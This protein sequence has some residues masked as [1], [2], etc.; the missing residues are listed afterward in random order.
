M[1]AH[2]RHH[3][4]RK[5]PRTWESR[6][7]G[8]VVS[9]FVFV[10]KQR[11]EIATSSRPAENG[12]QRSL[13]GSADAGSR[14]GS[15]LARPSRRR[16]MPVPSHSSLCFQRRWMAICEEKHPGCGREFTLFADTTRP[17]AC[18]TWLYT[19][20]ALLYKVS[21]GGG[22]PPGPSVVPRKVGC[23]PHRFPATPAAS[24]D[25]RWKEDVFCRE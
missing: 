9:S 21:L 5:F 19:F 10:V 14:S 20:P 11:S 4:N 17:V 24:R 6:I 16:N 7:Q 15:A 18:D 23:V 13:C 25:E 1:T 12:S 3:Q 22:C 2:E 8:E